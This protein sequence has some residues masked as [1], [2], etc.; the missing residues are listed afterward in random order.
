MVKSKVGSLSSADATEEKGDDHVVDDVADEFYVP[1]Y[2]VSSMH[3]YKANSSNTAVKTAGNGSTL[4]VKG[5]G[6]LGKWGSATHLEG[7]RLPLMSP[8]Q[9]W[10]EKRYRTTF[11]GH[12]TITDEHGEAITK[13]ERDKDGLYMIDLN[14][15][16]HLSCGSSGNAN[17]IASDRRGEGESGRE[18][19]KDNHTAMMANISTLSQAHKHYGHLRLS[20][21]KQLAKLGKLNNVSTA[22]WKMAYH[23]VLRASWER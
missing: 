16:N 5:K 17:N 12:C 18:E 3:N 22:E 2:M 6:K 20:G 4:L 11:D 8:G 7:L 23:C 13:D 1:D 15:A 21:L 19:H 14:L 10:T 9:L